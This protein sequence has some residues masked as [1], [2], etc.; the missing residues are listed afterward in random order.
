MILKI[1]SKILILQICTRS[2]TNLQI[3]F[4]FT[5]PFLLLQRT[6]GN[7]DI[8]LIKEVTKNT[9]TIHL[10]LCIIIGCNCTAVNLHIDRR[11]TLA[12]LKRRLEDY[13]L[14]PSSEFKVALCMEII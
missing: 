6:N 7:R 11:S 3:E 4:C 12:D 9:A 2:L 8:N 1:M 14:I 5:S 10:Q 13:V